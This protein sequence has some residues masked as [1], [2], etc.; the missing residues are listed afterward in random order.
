VKINH[1][2]IIRF[3]AWNHPIWNVITE[4]RLPNRPIIDRFFSANRPILRT[5]SSSIRQVQKQQSSRVVK[6]GQGDRLKRLNAI[7]IRQMKVLTAQS[8]KQLEG[9]KQ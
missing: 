9:G 1:P 4:R 3:S 2:I 5:E 8:L 6:W 7:A